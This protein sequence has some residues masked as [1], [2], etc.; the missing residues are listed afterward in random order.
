MDLGS[1]EVQPNKCQNHNRTKMKLGLTTK[2]INP[3]FLNFIFWGEKTKKTYP[4]T[5]G[6]TGFYFISHFAFGQLLPTTQLLQTT[7]MF[8]VNF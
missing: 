2:F 3:I 6:Q 5:G 4:Q 7:N 8:S 1:A